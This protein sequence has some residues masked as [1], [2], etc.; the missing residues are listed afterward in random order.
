MAEDSEDAASAGM[1]FRRRH[2]ASRRS[3]HGP[4]E[5]DRRELLVAV[6]T[7]AAALGLPGAALAQPAP[8]LTALEFASLSSAI[9]GF[10]PDPGLAAS[11][12]EAFSDQAAELA[13]L[14]DLL[15]TVP[16]EQ[17]EAKIAAEGLAPLAEA[18]ATAWY[19]GM[20]GEGADQRVLTYLDAFAWYAVAYTKPPT[21][22][23]IS[24]G[25]WAE[26]PHEAR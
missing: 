13:K 10:P 9:A 1:R 7:L 23:D 21:R 25:A 20:V 12:L 2:F 18:L 6:S 11:F 17:W 4:N 19:T 3:S 8:A 14:H 22:C 5:L 26:P 24:F 15:R 16:P